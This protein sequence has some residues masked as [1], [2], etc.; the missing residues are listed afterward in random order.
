MS[1]GKS[2]PSIKAAVFD[3]DGV[4]TDTAT[5]H[6]AAWKK[7]FDVFLSC[8]AQAGDEPFVP[9][10]DADYLRYVDGRARFDGVEAF[11]ASRRHHPSSRRAQRSA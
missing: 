6:A 8:R 1:T 2:L 3:T 5:V 4:V 7:M 10:G 9:F 11:L